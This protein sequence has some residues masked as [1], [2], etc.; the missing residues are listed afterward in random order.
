MNV[1]KFVLLG[2]DGAGKSAIINRV[3]TSLGTEAQ[4]KIFAFHLKTGV[5]RQIIAYPTPPSGVRQYGYILSI[6]KLVYLLVESHVRYINFVIRLCGCRRATFIYDRHVI[7][8]LFDPRR[9]GYNGPK[10]L[11][12]LFY[13]IANR[14][15]KVYII[16]AEPEKLVARKNELDLEEAEV[17]VRHYLKLAKKLKIPVIWNNGDI[18]SPIAKIITEMSLEK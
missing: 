13:S 6:F 9:F 17:I 18:S 15:N 12:P 5:V 4:Q 16:L 2:P 14:P 1:M 10:F 7:E 8:I 11:L 3:I